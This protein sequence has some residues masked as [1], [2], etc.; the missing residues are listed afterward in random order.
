MPNIDNKDNLGND[1]ENQN[2]IIPDENTGADSQKNV[3]FGG[4][5]NYQWNDR[6]YQDAIEKS[7][8]KK[9]GRNGGMILVVSILC[10]IC[11]ISMFTAGAF[12]VLY[13]TQNYNNPG[14]SS[15]DNQSNTSSS[16]QS[17]SD[18][19]SIPQN[20]PGPALT[21]AQAAAKVKPSVVSILVNTVSSS[22]ENYNA[23]GTGVIMSE[24]GYILTNAHVVE[25]ARAVK[26][27]LLDKREFSAE[28]IGQDTTTDLAV[29]KID[30]DNLTAAE[31]GKSSLLEIGE[32]VLAIGN[33]YDLE[34]NYT[35]THGIVS[36]IR[37]KITLGSNI[38][39]SLIQTDAPINPGNSGGPLVNM[40]GQVIGIN[41]LKIM[42]SN[43]TT[44]E[45]LGFAIPSDVAL[46]I[47]QSLIQH[48]YVKGRPMIGITGTPVTKTQTTP[49]GIL[50]SDVN[51]NSDAYA[52]GIRVGDII[53]K[54]N[55]KEFTSFADFNEEKQKFKVGDTIT[56]T[57]YRNGKYTTVSIVLGEDTPQ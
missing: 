28:I 47:A 34:L 36:G 17:S 49:A 22:T 20:D 19:S 38:N 55:D 42:S 41:S 13:F 56:L 21:K 11:L 52:K 14:T 27:I 3:S 44:A 57:Y 45:G 50:V 31:F 46:P 6:A 33:P 1:S 23:L 29:I 26:V 48:G 10:V 18:I 32:D 24:E 40:S 25:S 16:S 4:D 30:A 51:K 9:S 7:S 2:S 12:G 35:V 54:I 15:N 53:T 43:L 37:E 39:M 8:K 5:Y